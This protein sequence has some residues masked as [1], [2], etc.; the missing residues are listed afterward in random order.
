VVRQK[1]DAEAG[2]YAEAIAMLGLVELQY[3]TISALKPTVTMKVYVPFLGDTTEE[4]QVPGAEYSFYNEVRG[5]YNIATGIKDVS[6]IPYM[7]RTLLGQVEAIDLLN[8]EKQVS[9]KV[10]DPEIIDRCNKAVE[11]FL[12]IIKYP[13]WTDQMKP[14]PTLSYFPG[15]PKWLSENMD[16]VFKNDPFRTQI[17]E[18]YIRRGIEMEPSLLNMLK[19]ETANERFNAAIA[20]G[21]LRSEAAVKVAEEMMI[22]EAD[23]LVRIGAIFILVH[24]GETKLQ[25]ELFLFLDDA[26]EITAYA[27]AIALEHLPLPIPDNVLEKH[28]RSGQRL[29]Q[30]RF[31]YHVLRHMNANPAVRDAVSTLVFNSNDELGIAAAETMS[32]LLSNDELFNLAKQKLFRT[33]GNPRIRRRLMLML[34]HARTDAAVDLLLQEWEMVK[35]KRKSDQQGAIDTLKNLGETHSLRV[36]PILVG[37]LNYDTDTFFYVALNALMELARQYPR[38]VHDA[39]KGIRNIYKRRKR[40]VQALIS[41]EPGEVEAFKKI[42]LLHKAGMSTRMLHEQASMMIAHP[43]FEDTF[44]SALEP[45]LTATGGDEIVK[46]ENRYNASKI[47]LAGLIERA[48]T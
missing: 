13:K 29:V 28:L 36:L 39:L 6:K 25:Q 20:L 44:E 19:G 18:A 10:R 40:F 47:S 23:P 7:L 26:N 17:L 27:A 30:L 24:N 37:V 8:L 46:I 3:K 4:R 1:S 43:A 16:I 12:K 32:V 31:I 9:F 48:K 22:S 11:A 45:L 5:L 2:F 34:G 38:E 33:G 41:G 14:I 21:I 42:Y 15:Y 35:K